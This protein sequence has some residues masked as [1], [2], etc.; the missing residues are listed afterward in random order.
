MMFILQTYLY[1]IFFI[2]VLIACTECVGFYDKPQCV[3][4]CPIDCIPKDPNHVETHDQLLQK[5]RAL[6]RNKS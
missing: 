6:W 5:Q 1:I 3:E 2:R 4:A